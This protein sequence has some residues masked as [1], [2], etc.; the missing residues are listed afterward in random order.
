MAPR[1]GVLAL[2]GDVLEHMQ[3]LER[4]GAVPFR[5]R[6]AEE[7]AAAQG[8]VLPG[9]ESSVIG[10][11][12][13]RYGLMDPAREAV[14]QGLPD[15]GTCAGLIL[16]AREI[17]DGNVPRLAVLDVRVRRNAFGRQV[18]SFEADLEVPT[19]G[20]PA[21]RG[22]FIRAP[23]ILA[24]GRGVEVLAELPSG[25]VLVRQGQLLAGAFHPELTDDLRVHEYFLQMVRE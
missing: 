23:Q 3:A 17:E 6:D 22:V 20:Q 4:A 25:P 19:L 13:E 18:D 11:L 15:L 21:L 1:V 24:M 9:G 10:M 12:L 2:Q 14:R 5:V 7:L 8:L 16:M